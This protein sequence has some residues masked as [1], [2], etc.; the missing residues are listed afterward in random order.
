MQKYIKA[1]VPNPACLHAN[2]VATTS[3]LLAHF[4]IETVNKGEIQTKAITVISQ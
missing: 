3:R 4:N 2:Y 1:V